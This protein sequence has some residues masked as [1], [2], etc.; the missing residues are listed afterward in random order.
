M[1]SV[2]SCW[3]AR[4]VYPSHVN[5]L[6]EPKVLQSLFVVSFCQLRGANRVFSWCGLFSPRK[7]PTI[8]ADLDALAHPIELQLLPITAEFYL[9]SLLQIDAT[10][11]LH[12]NNLATCSWFAA[13]LQLAH[14]KRKSVD[15][16]F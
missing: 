1:F 5:G 8:G 10:N 6:F 4:T 11:R 7:A 2:D 12:G 3:C 14:T 16:S 13:G 9:V 15:A